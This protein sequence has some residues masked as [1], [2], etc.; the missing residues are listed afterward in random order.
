[1]VTFLLLSGLHNNEQKDVQ[2]TLQTDRK[3]QSELHVRK[4]LTCQSEIGIENF[5][6]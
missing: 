3:F 1:M 5:H 6:E 2:E 4:C